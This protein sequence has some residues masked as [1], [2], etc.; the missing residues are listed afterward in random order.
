MLIRPAERRDFPEIAAIYAPFVTDTRVSFEL[1]PP[2]ADEMAR[3]WQEIVSKGY[4]YLVAEHEG[5]VAG[6]AYAGQYRTRA[7]YDWTV[8][9]SIYLGH[10]WR[11]QGIGRRLLEELIEICT[12]M[13]FRQ[14]VAGVS[15]DPDTDFAAG[16]IAFHK[17][18]GFEQ[19][20]V[21]PAVG[22]KTGAWVDVVFLQRAL[23][24]GASSPPG[25]IKP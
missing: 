1:T 10:N 20:A 12:G 18:L 22:F 24:D 13:G 7:A 15:T 19:V 8:E 2:D 11:G 6:Y 17:A 4:P 23:G 16:S 25:Q 3:R 14:M 9:D 21:H 5:E